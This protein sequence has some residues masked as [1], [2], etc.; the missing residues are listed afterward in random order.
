MFENL[1]L[2]IDKRRELSVKYKKI[3]EMN[4]HSVLITSSILNA[5]KIMQDYEPDIIIISDTIE[6]NLA[7]F[8][9]KIRV[10]TFNSRPVIIGLSKSS[11]LDDKLNILNAGADDFISEPIDVKEF[12]ARINAHI[13]RHEQTN[14]TD[15]VGLPNNKYAYRVLKRVLKFNVDYGVMLVE[16][17]NFGLYEEAY[18]TLAANKVLLTFCAITKSALE[19]SDFLSQV[20]QNSFLLI[21][22]SQNAEKL[23]SFLINAF[24]S[25]LEKFYN[26]AD[27][28]DGFLM[29]RGSEKEERRMPFMMLNIGVVCAETDKN[30][31]LKSLLNALYTVQRLAKQ[32]KKSGYILERPKLCGDVKEQR[33]KLL[34][35]EKDE[36]LLCLL[37]ESA[38]LRNIENKALH[39][40]E[41]VLGE[42]KTCAPK[43]V[44]L[45]GGCA[46]TQEGLELCQKIKN[47]E[48]GENIKIILTT[49]SRDKKAVL[50]SG[51]DLYLPK[52][53]DI[54]KLFK[55]VEKFLDEAIL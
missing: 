50:S 15:Y 18:G 33:Q 42:I 1:I 29:L 40:K 51:A 38:N 5:F 43:V 21:T 11:H 20:T 46:Q 25:V 37:S 23:A 54:S 47:L 53:Y 39:P 14:L 7:D 17:S 4:S 8:C 13:R 44:I 22:Q 19:K 30:R 32:N 24:D 28:L 27:I 2:I 55:W 16:I 9:K 26:E 45:D 52:P 34:I 35:I 41:D 49:V 10:L 12:E 3:L 36:A 48:G 6:E 31:D